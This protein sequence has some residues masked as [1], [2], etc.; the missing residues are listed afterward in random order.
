MNTTTPP[1]T[2]PLNDATI[3]TTQ[4]AVSKTLGGLL[5]PLEARLAKGFQSHRDKPLVRPFCNIFERHLKVELDQQSFIWSDTL[6]LNARLVQGIEAAAISEDEK[7]EAV[8]WLVLFYTSYFALGYQT[9]CLKA[10]AE[11][12]P[13]LNLAQTQAVLP[14]CGPSGSSNPP[15]RRTGSRTV[16]CSRR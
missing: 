14:T 7:N 8:F 15:T 6:R 16:T 3:A 9:R 11:Q 2:R 12:Q 1:A 5:S 10:P 13:L 4:R